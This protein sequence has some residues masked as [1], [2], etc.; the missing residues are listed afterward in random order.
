MELHQLE[1]FVAVA[2]FRS[3]HRAAE[4]LYLSQ[5]AVSARIQALERALGKRLF[6]RDGRTVRLTE[7]GEALLPY[8][9]RA[10]QAVA[11]GQHAVQQSSARAAGPL[12]LAAVP[13]ICTY[14]LPE[15]VKRFR[16][17]CTDCKV[18]IR[19]GHS[20]EVLQMVLNEEAELG[21]ARSLSHP[22][23]ETIHLAQDPFVLVVYPRHRF[24]RAGRVRLDE[25][26][27]EPLIFYDRGSSDWTLLTAAFRQRALLPNVV[28]E[29][30]TIEAAK[31]MVERE[32]GISLLPKMAI[33]REIAEGTLI[34]VRLAGADLPKRH[35][36]LIYLRGRGLGERA[37]QFVRLVRRALS[38][39]EERR[40]NKQR[41]WPAPLTEAG[42]GG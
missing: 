37:Q 2:T 5:P 30:D 34:P 31:K 11:E 4:A 6:E 32:V 35:V 19:T 20:R 1:A 15:V 17:E 40:I 14:L 28:L 8:A 38:A 39:A 7:A 18:L 27:S 22:Q 21:L 13:T 36:D 23:V 42:A 16:Q 41:A 29:L 10:I 24:A 25:V 9:E 26:A 33:R 12:T 3:F